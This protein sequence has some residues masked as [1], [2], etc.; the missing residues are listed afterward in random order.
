[1][2]TLSVENLGPVKSAKVE[3]GDLTVLVGPQATGKSV[4]LQL[5][6]LLIDVGPIRAELR[7]FNI[8]WGGSLENFMDLYFGEGMSGIFEG[9]RTAIAYDASAIRLEEWLGKRLRADEKKERLFFIP[10]QR[11]LSLREGATRPFTDYRSGDPFV[12]REFS[13]KLHYLVQSEFAQSPIL[14]PKRNRLKDQ[15]RR[16]LD[17]NIFGGFGLRTDTARFQKRL[18]LSSPTSNKALPYLVWSAGQREFVPLL[19]GLYWLIPPAR[20]PRRAGLEWVVIEEPEMG[21]HPKAISV[22]MLLVLE[23]LHRGYRVCLSTHS[24]HVLDVV[25]A[26]QVMKGQGGSDKEVF[27]LFSVKATPPTRKLATDVLA[28]RYAVYYFQRDGKVADISQ[29]DPGSER[30]AEAGW[31]GLSE[32][33][34]NVGDIVARV[35]ARASGR[36]DPHDGT[37]R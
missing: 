31:G 14:F 3:F 33:S 1:M 17:A 12:V 2:T 11:V 34:G 9:A 29:L 24:P 4:F 6:K 36:T 18:V 20:V 10:A 15:F 27:D 28:K 37:R 25:W 35:V 30:A 7:R 32:F 5:F 26:L 21:L 13:E 16:L 19:M 23:L 22:V 8:D